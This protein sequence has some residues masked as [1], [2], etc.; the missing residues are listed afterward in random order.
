MRNILILFA[1]LVICQQAHCGFLFGLS[2]SD[3]ETEKVGIALGGANDEHI[4]NISIIFNSQYSED[5]FLDTPIP[6]TDYTDLGDKRIGNTFGFDYAKI[7]N[8]DIL[9]GLPK[10]YVGG[11][12]YFGEKARI[13]KSNVTGWLWAQDKKSKT[14]FGFVAG[15]LFD[16]NQFRFA[17]EYHG[18][19]GIGLTVV[20]N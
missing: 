14:D 10:P 1:T 6:H 8:L 2:P 17:F 3:R 11:G 13:V 16:L 18:V 19:K 15:V 9:S 12:L 4:G 7:L 20:L 5:D